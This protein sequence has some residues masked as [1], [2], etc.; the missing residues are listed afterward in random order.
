[1]TWPEG[2]RDER[3]TKHPRS[4]DSVYSAGPKFRAIRTY[5]KSNGFCLG[6]GSIFGRRPAHSPRARGICQ[7]LDRLRRVQAYG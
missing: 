2:F 1:M 7:F 3:V 5:I 4:S 6:P